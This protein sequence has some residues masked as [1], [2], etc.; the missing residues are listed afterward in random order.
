V[1]SKSPL[2]GDFGFVPKE[3]LLDKNGQPG[4]TVSYFNDAKFEAKVAEQTEPM[5]NLFVNEGATPHPKIPATF[6]YSIRWEGKIVPPTTG[7]YQFDLKYGYGGN[8]KLFIDGKSADSTSRTSSV[9]RMNLEAGKAVTLVIELK[10]L[11]YTGS[12]MLR[13]SVPEP[14][15][16]DAQKIIDRVKNEGTTLIILD[17]SDAWMPLIA[18]NTAIKY[19]GKFIVGRDW[20]GGVHFVKAH[21]LFKDLPVNEGMNWQ[22]EAVVKNGPE[23]MGLELE[24]EELVAGAYHCF[25][26]KLGTA[27]GVIPCGKGKIVFSTLEIYNNLNAEESTSIVAKKLL[28]NYINYAKE[29]K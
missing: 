19:A 8:I 17:N 12:C 3:Q 16:I 29:A 25:P 24:G 13:W 18:K 1:T 7:T 27:I 28:C 4:I 5:I 9:M 23:R 15:K 20:L 21:P 10:H 14:I 6:N 2:G 26:M 22:Y 11:R